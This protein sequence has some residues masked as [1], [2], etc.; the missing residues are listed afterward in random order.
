M[1]RGAPWAI[2][3]GGLAGAL[4]RWSVLDLVGPVADFPWPVFVL[5]VGGSLVLGAAMV[6]SRRRGPTVWR[7]GIGIGFCG[8]VTTFSTFAVEAAGL[9]RDDRAALALG[10]VTTSVIAAVVAVVVGAAVVGGLGAVEAIDD[11]LE[12]DP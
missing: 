10:Y 9:V 8:G 1:S 12:S 5:N 7:D 3:V 11:P 2:A 6:E 4:L